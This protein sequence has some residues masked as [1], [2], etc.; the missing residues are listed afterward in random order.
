M[1]ILEGQ[2][3][4]ITPLNAVRAK[5]LNGALNL[6]SFFHVRRQHGARLMVRIWERANAIRLRATGIHLQNPKYHVMP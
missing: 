1:E 6:E 3:G 5:Q 2:I 4:V